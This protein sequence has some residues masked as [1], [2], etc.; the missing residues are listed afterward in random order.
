MKLRQLMALSIVALALTMIA[1]ASQAHAAPMPITTCGQVVTTDSVLT[2]D[3]TCDVTAITVGTSGI[4]IDLKGHVLKNEASASVNG[5]DLGGYNDVKVKNGIVRGFRIGL[6]SG[7]GG[8][9]D[10]GGTKIQIDNVLVV[11]NSFGMLLTGPDV[12]VKSSKVN[13]NQ[14][15]IL[16][17]G[18]SGGSAEVASSTIIGNVSWGI[19]GLQLGSLVIRDSIVSAN[20]DTGI[21]VTWY[22]AAQPPHAARLTN[23]Q[24]DANGYSE[25]RGAARSDLNGLGIRYTS[26]PGSLAPAG[27]NQA[28]G[29]DDPTECVPVSLC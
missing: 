10:G 3:L 24:V 15:G 28:S 12:S 25:N 9:F 16:L 4:T 2:Q 6:Y 27:K 19:L 8:G 11:E 21:D 13:R 23:N 18:F 14:V 1:A 5:I 22:T 26:P 29:N 20:G 17:T 7:V